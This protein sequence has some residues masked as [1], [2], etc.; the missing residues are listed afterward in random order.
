MAIDDFI[1]KR[2]FEPVEPAGWLSPDQA[3]AYNRDGFLILRDHV[4]ADWLARLK[5][6]VERLVETGHRSQK[7]IDQKDAEIAAF[8]AS[9]PVTGTIELFNGPSALLQAFCFVKLPHEQRTKPYHQDGVYWQTSD[10]RVACVFVAL[11]EATPDNGCIY[12]LP[13][14]HRLGRLY[15]WVQHDEFG[16]EN[17][18]CDIAPL[19]RPVPMVLKPGDAVVAH[20]LTVHG[21]FGNA[22]DRPRISLGFH[23]RGQATT[24]E[25][26]SPYRRKRQSELGYDPAR[27]DAA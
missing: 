27:P 15:H 3:A 17:L 8:V 16:L 26:L 11:T 12:F 18:E 24:L 20:T 14:S 23:F 25:L 7:D 1:D 5:G 10:S 4:P 22:T 13:G 9:D 2:H 19:P 6:P 21:S